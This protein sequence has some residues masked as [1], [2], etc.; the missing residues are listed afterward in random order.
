MTGIPQE[1]RIKPADILGRRGRG[2]PKSA[3]ERVALKI[4]VRADL[5][6]RYDEMARRRFGGDR[7]RNQLMEEVLEKG[8]ADRE[9]AEAL[10]DSEDRE[11][12]DLEILEAAQTDPAD[13]ENWEDR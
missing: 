12:S 5:R 3:I 9:K 2:Q 10:E 11:D 8:L 7:K 1:S 13:R 6:D 4:Y